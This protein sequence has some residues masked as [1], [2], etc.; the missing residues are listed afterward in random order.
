MKRRWEYG[1]IFTCCRCSPEQRRRERA[2][3]ADLPSPACFY[4]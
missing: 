3:A 1:V 4:C 2:S